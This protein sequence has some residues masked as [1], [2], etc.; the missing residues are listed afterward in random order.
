M[1]ITLVIDDLNGGG[2]E[3]V[4]CI[5][6]NFWAQKGWQVTVI[7]TNQGKREPFYQ[8]LPS[9]NHF[10]LE[11]EERAK[12]FSLLRPGGAGKKWTPPGIKGLILM[13]RLKQL[14]PRTR[15]QVVLSFLDQLSVQTLMVAGSGP[16]PI[17]V[18]ERIDPHH[19][20]LTD[21]WVRMRHKYY[22]RAAKVVVQTRAGAKY[23]QE[24]VQ[25][26]IVV[27]PNPV[28][29]PEQNPESGILPF[30][31]GRNRIMTAGRLHRQKGFDLLLEA[32][33]GLDS[34]FPNW[35][36]FVFGE[37]GERSSLEAQIERLGLTNRAFLVGKTGRPI[38]AMEQSDIFVLSSRF[39]GFPNV[40]C[41]A[42][43][44]GCAVVSYAC[45]TGPDEIIEDGVNGLLVPNVGDIAGLRDAL[46][47]LMQDKNLR[48]EL[49]EAAPDVLKRFPLD[50][51]MKMW[52][53]TLVP[54]AL[55]N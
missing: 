18:S 8:L 26:K 34:E 45:P 27:I 49:S 39:E 20:E 4:L 41:E 40:L 37:G 15:P 9:V 42:M 30:R 36:L 6:A 14:I 35:D 21:F 5:M 22:R 55:P 13:L 47:R 33:Q 31:E 11:I 10:D 25:P 3:R 23:F 48:G 44:S 16:A 54:L 51:V 32:F 28:I 53:D 12:V 29:I 24:N 52:E 7:T 50:V 38:D 43:A 2:A 46:R 17:V 1:R 19:H